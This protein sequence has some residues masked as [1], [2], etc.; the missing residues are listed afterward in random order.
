MATIVVPRSERARLAA[1]RVYTLAWAGAG[2]LLAALSAPSVGRLP[3]EYALLAVLS[4]VGHLFFVL[5]VPGG[6]RLSLQPILA[7]V[8]LYGWRAGPPLFA[9]TFPLVLLQTRKEPLRAA[10]YFGNGC[11]WASAAGLVYSAL[12][13]QPSPEPT[14]GE[15]ASALA[16][17]AV[18]VLGGFVVEAY[19][20]ALATG[21]LRMLRSAHVREALFLLFA[22]NAAVAY[23]LLL[24]MHGGPAASLLAAAVWAVAAVAIQALVEARR[25]N[26]RLRETLQ[27]LERLSLTDPL[28]GL[29]NRRQFVQVLP[30]ELKRHAGTGR[31]LSL[32]VVDLRSLKQ[33][34]DL[35]G[36]EAGD[37]LLQHAAEVF[38]QRLRDSDSSFRI[39]GDEFALLLPET[40]T[41]G[42]ITVARH[43]LEQLASP[44]PQ[45][46]HL[47][48]DATVGVGTFPHHAHEAAALVA[49]ADA[50]LY[51]ARERGQ[52]VGTPD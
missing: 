16:S 7:A 18:Y 4:V 11:A 2:A 34:N 23:L 31:P 22:S 8:W 25:A 15:L 29:W 51:R 9:L 28:T 10:L 12:R 50:A 14:W 41:P 13:G 45:V 20:R 52:S 39:G 49:A 46:S 26:E 38:R 43:I 3:L 6:L 21:E 27:E 1:Y 44:P 40:D 37:R 19:G 30:A 48:V 24:A 5:E 32:L 17:G 36:H 35:Y 47:P 42:A 33:V